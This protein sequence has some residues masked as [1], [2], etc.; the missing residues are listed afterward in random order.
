MNRTIILILCIAF[1]FLFASQASGQECVD[2][3][4]GCLVLS[5]NPDYWD[6]PTPP[7][8]GTFDLYG[9]LV[10]NPTCNA[11]GVRFRLDVPQG[12]ILSVSYNDA[13]IQSVVGDSITYGVEI[14]LS[15]C[16]EGDSYIDLFHI[17]T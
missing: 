12:I 6:C 13:V 17:Q 5:G 4:R 14:S 1:T 7:Y 2:M 15:D 9:M 11:K 3:L 10:V 8:Y 16:W